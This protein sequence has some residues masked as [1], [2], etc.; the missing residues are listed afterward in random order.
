MQIPLCK[1]KIKCE[2]LFH[3]KGKNHSAGIYAAVC[4]FMHSHGYT[5][6]EYMYCHKT[7]VPKYKSYYLDCLWSC[8]LPESAWRSILTT[9][10]YPSNTVKYLS[11]SVSYL[12]FVSIFAWFY[13]I[14]LL[15]VF[16]FCFFSYG[17]NWFSVIRPPPQKKKRK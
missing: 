17:L 10:Y 9:K 8:I 5:P 6:S 2:T 3:K 1:W 15:F 14:C 16:F 4:R 12:G 11:L 7:S 13:S